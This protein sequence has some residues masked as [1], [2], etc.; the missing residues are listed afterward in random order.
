MEPEQ[1]QRVYVLGAHSCPANLRRAQPKG[2]F[3]WIPF[4]RDD[5]HVSISCG[6]RRDRANGNRSRWARGQLRDSHSG[7]AVEISLP[8]WAIVACVPLITLTS[9]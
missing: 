4:V 1:M 7:Y 3:A 6:E 8:S 5:G 2:R 9:V